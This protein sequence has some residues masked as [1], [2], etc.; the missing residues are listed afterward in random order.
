MVTSVIKPF[1]KLPWL[2]LASSMFLVLAGCNEQPAAKPEIVRPVKSIIVQAP[3]LERNRSFPGRVEATGKVNLAFKVAGALTDLPIKQGQQ[4]KKGQILAKLDSRDY[5]SNYK[6]AS[7][8][9]TR[10]KA[11]YNRAAEIFKR[12]LISKADVDRLKATLSIA[13]T[14]VEK[15]RKAVNDTTMK[16]PFSGVIANL[17]VDNFQDV[18]AKEPILSL[19]DNSALDIVVQVPESVVVKSGRRTHD[20]DLQASFEAFPEKS[21]TLSIKEFSTEA[22][23]DTQ[24]FQYVLTMPAPKEINALPGMSVTVTAQPRFTPDTPL[25]EESTIKI[26]AMAVFADPAGQNQ[27]FVW[28]YDDTSQTVNRREVAIGLL[29][30]SLVEVISGLEAGERIVTAGVHYLQPGQKVRLFEDQAGV[31]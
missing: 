18:N 15:T 24:T 29:G 2:I 31:N 12:N 1:K 22:D 4:V 14:D 10:A 25:A 27:Q 21:F 5:R 7:A 23:P 9:Y 26:P 6:A 16:A 30:G 3:S 20:V 17:Y 28:I 13:A 8:E 11:D 19:Q